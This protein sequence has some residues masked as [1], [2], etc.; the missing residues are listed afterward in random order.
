MK[1]ETLSLLLISQKVLNAKS[2]PDSCVYFHV[3]THIHIHALIKFVLR[4]K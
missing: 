4:Y 3:H 2:V 1:V